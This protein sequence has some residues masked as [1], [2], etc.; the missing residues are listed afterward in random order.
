MDEKTKEVFG[1]WAGSLE[2]CFVR[3]AHVEELYQAFKNRFVED[4]FTKA[5]EPDQTNPFGVEMVY[6][7]SDK[8]KVEALKEAVEI[9]KSPWNPDK[10]YPYALIDSMGRWLK[11]WGFDEHKAAD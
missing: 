7:S 2:N 10:I 11:K 9:M 8:K 3:G 5:P 4:F 6:L 1:I